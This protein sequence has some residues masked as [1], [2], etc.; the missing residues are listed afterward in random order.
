MGQG[1]ADA[2][3]HVSLQHV[4][5]RD[6]TPALCF[7]PCPVCIQGVWIRTLQRNPNLVLYMKSSATGPCKS[8]K[9]S[10]EPCKPETSWT[11]MLLTECS[12]RQHYHRNSTNGYLLHSDSLHQHIHPR[13]TSTAA[14]PVQPHSLAASQTMSHH[15]A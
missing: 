15:T 5:W 10:R 8:C 1:E 2:L 12:P 3:S 4:L 11:T 9:P 13:H 6:S 14:G 7:T